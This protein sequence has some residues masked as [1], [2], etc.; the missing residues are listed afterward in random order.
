MEVYQWE[1]ADHTPLLWPPVQCIS[2]PLSLKSSSRDLNFSL[3][4]L[5]LENPG[6]K[7][8]I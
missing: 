7:L 4:F 5:L 6:D 3:V 8:M 1:V 2:Y